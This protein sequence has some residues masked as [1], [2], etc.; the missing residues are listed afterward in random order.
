MPV[1]TGSK[2][3]NLLVFEGSRLRESEHA[4][5]REMFAQQSCTFRQ[6][7]LRNDEYQHTHRLEPAIAMVEEDQFQ[8]LV[9]TLPGF[10]IIRRIQIKERYRFRLAPHVHCVRLQSL[11]S[12]GAC[13]F[14]PI[15]IDLNAIA[16]GGCAVQQVS[17]A[18]PFS[19]K[20]I[21]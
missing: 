20:R 17:E 5:V 7:Q 10:P 13:S 2:P 3:Y 9:V 15:G 21:D 16:M 19:H 18:H 8:P 14:G 6:S 12:Q 11:D 4:Q 1:S